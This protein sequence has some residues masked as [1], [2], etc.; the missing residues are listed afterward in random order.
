[1]PSTWP[2][3]M[4]PPSS[5]PSRSARSRLS[6]VPRCQVPAVVIRSV[7]AAASTAKNGPIAGPAALHDGQAD[8]GTGDRGADVDAVGIVAAGD[9]ETAQ[10]LGLLLNVNNFA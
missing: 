8:A 2:L 3:T 1:M 7:S 9:G 10:A 4:W 5:S 6:L